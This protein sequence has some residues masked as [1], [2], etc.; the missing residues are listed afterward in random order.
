MAGGYGLVS[1]DEDTVYLAATGAGLTMLRRT[2]PLV[3]PPTPTPTPTP[4]MDARRW[5]VWLPWLSDVR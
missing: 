5:T 4:T 3:R 2:G 1:G